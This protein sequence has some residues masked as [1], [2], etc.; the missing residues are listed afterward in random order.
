[1]V[2]LLKSQAVEPPQRKVPFQASRNSRHLRRDTRLAL[3][4]L[5]SLETQEGNTDAD[6]QLWEDSMIAFDSQFQSMRDQFAYV[7]AFASVYQER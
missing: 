1:M 7:D 5:E 6:W 2:R 3:A 4:V